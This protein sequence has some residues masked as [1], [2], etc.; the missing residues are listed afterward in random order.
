MSDFRKLIT[1]NKTALLFLAKFVIFYFVLNTAYGFWVESYYP[2]ADPITVWVSKHTAWILS[3][4]HSSINTVAEPLSVYVAITLIGET[5]IHV[6]EGCNSI[7][8]MIV[9]G[10]F[11]LAFSNRWYQEW[12]FLLLGLIT[13]YIMNLARV[14]GLFWMALY[15]PD[16]LY[17]FHKYLFTGMIYG[18]VFLLWFVWVSNVQKRERRTS[19]S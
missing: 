12:K 15:F 19:G 16:S 1:E 11:V 6:F 10:V 9:F 4:F 2:S 18:V 7:N 13:I 8:V 17:F 5:I 3:F 14:T